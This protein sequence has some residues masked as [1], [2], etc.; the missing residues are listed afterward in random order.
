MK[1][2][3]LLMIIVEAVV[4]LVVTVRM[5]MTTILLIVKGIGQT[6]AV[7]LLYMRLLSA[8]YIQLFHLRR[9]WSTSP[10]P[11]CCSTTGV[12]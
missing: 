11:H 10:C 5:K 1:M 8:Y 3:I 2:T 12:P 4:V 6:Q 9:A 7:P